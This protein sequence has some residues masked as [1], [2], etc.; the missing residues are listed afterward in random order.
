MARVG[1][2]A[3]TLRLPEAARMHPTFHVSLL[4]KCLN[5]SIAPVHPPK[6]VAD[7]EMMRKPTSILDQ[8]LVQRKGRVVIEVLIRWKGEDMEEASWEDWQ[9]VQIKFPAFAKESHP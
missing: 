3:Y 9:E 1:Q 4:K 8:R 6:E 7:T 2:V 5:P